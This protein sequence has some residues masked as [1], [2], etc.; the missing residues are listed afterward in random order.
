MKKSYLKRLIARL[1]RSGNM[2]RWLAKQP[3]VVEEVV[4]RLPDCS[5]EE[6]IEQLLERYHNHD[7]DAQVWLKEVAQHKPEAL[8][9]RA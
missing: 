9:R 6:L 1:S 2:I 5:T 7:I 3:E 8:L 4:Q